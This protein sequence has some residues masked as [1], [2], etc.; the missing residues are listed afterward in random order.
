MAAG[1]AEQRQ[2]DVEED[3]S[4]LQFPK[5]VLLKRCERRGD[6]YKPPQKH[7]GP[8]NVMATMPLPRKGDLFPETPLD[9]GGG[10]GAAAAQARWAKWP[11][12]QFATTRCLVMWN[13]LSGDIWEGMQCITCVSISDSGRS[14][15]RIP[16]ESHPRSTC[17]FLA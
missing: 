6:A 8:P 1:N 12:T 3:A 11:T 15:V 17:C 2:G 5:G 4:Q 14:V 13:V 9:Y 10:G 16:A 7:V